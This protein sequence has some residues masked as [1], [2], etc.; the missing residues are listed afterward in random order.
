VSTKDDR[1]QVWF[2]H[3]ACFKDRLYAADP[4]IDLSPAHF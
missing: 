2:C 4:S 1:C 3:A